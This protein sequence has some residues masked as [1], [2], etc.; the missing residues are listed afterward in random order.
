MA[1]CSRICLVCF[2]PAGL[3]A[4]PGQGQQQ[5][6][7]KG[8]RI[9]CPQ[10]VSCQAVWHLICLRQGRMV[11]IRAETTAM[12]CRG[13]PSGCEW[14]HWQTPVIAHIGRHNSGSLVTFCMHRVRETGT[15]HCFAPEHCAQ[16][17]KSCQPGK[18]CRCCDQ[19]GHLGLPRQQAGPLLAPP[20]GRAACSGEQ[21]GPAE[22]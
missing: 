17:R 7:L 21:S 11:S 9:A 18:S 15:M 2:R 16:S 19:V 3:W 14:C 1:G 5:Q 22:P 10:Q 8:G 4:V 6:G 12:L 13:I 20:A